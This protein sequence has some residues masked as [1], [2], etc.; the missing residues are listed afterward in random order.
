MGRGLEGLSPVTVVAKTPW[1]G[2]GA[3]GAVTCDCRGG[4][5]RV[6]LSQGQLMGGEQGCPPA[7]LVRGQ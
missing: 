1:E 3:G 4:D 5:P 2:E 6:Q 7:H